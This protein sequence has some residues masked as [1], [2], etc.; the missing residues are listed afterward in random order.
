M[1]AQALVNFPGHGALVKDSIDE[2]LF[3]PARYT[4]LLLSMGAVP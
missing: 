3:D 1:P 2:Q 4:Y